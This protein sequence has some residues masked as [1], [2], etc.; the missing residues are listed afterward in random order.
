MWTTSR[1]I[2][3]AAVF[4]TPYEI[5]DSLLAQTAFPEVLKEEIG[6]TP[7]QLTALCQDYY[8]DAF[9]RRQFVSI[10]NNKIGCI[11]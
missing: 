9:I 3:H 4:K 5:A 1:R 6:M 10:L 2:V 8:R 11:V 7:Q